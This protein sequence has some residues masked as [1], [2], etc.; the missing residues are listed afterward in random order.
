LLKGHWSSCFLWCYGSA[1]HI[2][3]WMLTVMSWMERRAPNG[4]AFEST[5]G[6]DSV[7]NH[8]GW[9]TIWCN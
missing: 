4:G 1:W 7:C 9:I 5:Q 8:I 2:Q 6:A 3:K